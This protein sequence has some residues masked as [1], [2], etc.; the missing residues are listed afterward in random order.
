MSGVSF[1][2]DTSPCVVSSCRLLAY[3]HI[4]YLIIHLKKKKS[5]AGKS[6]YRTNLSHKWTFTSGDETETAVG[7]ADNQNENSFP[8]FK[9]VILQNSALTL[10]F[11][12]RFNYKCKGM[13]IAFQRNFCRRKSLLLEITTSAWDACESEMCFRSDKTVV[14]RARIENS[15][16]CVGENALSQCSSCCVAGVS[17]SIL[18]FCS[19]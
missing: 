6:L 19:V 8:H 7:D 15:C 3:L 1:L 4:S 11:L 18:P 5:L 12:S 10:C 14:C 17:E 16:V 13:C 2:N 9:L